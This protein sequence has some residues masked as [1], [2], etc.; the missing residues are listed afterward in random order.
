MKFKEIESMMD[1]TI[2][3]QTKMF[4]VLRNL[5]NGNVHPLILDKGQ[6]F[7]DINIRREMKFIFVK[8]MDLIDLTKLKEGE[9]SVLR[10]ELYN[11]DHI[12]KILLR[13]MIAKCNVY[14]KLFVHD[15]SHLNR[16]VSINTDESDNVTNIVE[17][18]CI[19]I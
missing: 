1:S 5:K 8:N 7:L 6:K 15:M 14:D 19:D 2:N 12:S 17:Y 10:T 16:F 18:V 3:E 4:V 13:D 11:K 9:Y